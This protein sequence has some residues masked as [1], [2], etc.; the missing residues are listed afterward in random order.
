MSKVFARCERTPPELPDLV[1]VAYF[2]DVAYPRSTHCQET[3]LYTGH[4]IHLNSSWSFP[5][6]RLDPTLEY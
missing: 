3:F 5:E 4:D 6:F 1:N 2:I